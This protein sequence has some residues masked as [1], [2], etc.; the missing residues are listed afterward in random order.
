LATLG[1][2]M[3]SIA[4]EINQPLGAIANNAGACVRWLASRNLEKAERSA[5]LVIKDAHRAGEIITR[6][7]S[8]A[9]KAPP[10]KTWWILTRRLLK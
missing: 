8:L 3:T 9:K 1:E 4:H 2:L 6:I 7:R 10:Q 5:A